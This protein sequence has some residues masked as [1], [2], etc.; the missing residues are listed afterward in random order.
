M[1]T[2]LEINKT[3][4][5]CD[6]CRMVCPE[7]SIVTDGTEYAIDNWSCTLCGLCIEICPIDCI[8]EAKD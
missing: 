1:I 2:K 3:C 7:K 4:I 5:S 6:A 8:K